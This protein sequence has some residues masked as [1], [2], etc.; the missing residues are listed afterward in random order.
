MNAYHF[1]LV[2]TGYLNRNPLSNFL[3]GVLFSERISLSKLTLYIR[4]SFPS[5]DQKL[6]YFF[7]T[8][9]PA[10]TSLK[11]LN[12]KFTFS[13]ERKIDEKHLRKEIKIVIQNIRGVRSG[14]FTPDLAFERIVKEQVEQLATAPINTVDQVTT[15]IISAVRQCSEVRL[16]FPV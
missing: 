16:F 4:I 14:L 7:V 5:I 11:V 8:I 9:N 2:R 15:E 1:T 6:K 12:L 13:A 10:I 3:V